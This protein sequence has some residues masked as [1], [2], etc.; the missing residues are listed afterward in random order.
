MA[1]IRKP[2]RYFIN[3]AKRF[4]AE[5]ANS[6][7][8][9]NEKLSRFKW[10]KFQYNFS[11]IENCINT[12]KKFNV[13]AGSSVTQ[14]MHIG[15]V[16]RFLVLR[17]FE[18]LGAESFFAVTDFT[19]K[20]SNPETTTRFIKDIMALGINPNFIV[21]SWGNYQRNNLLMQIANFV[22]DEDLNKTYGDLK[23]DFRGKINTLNALTTMWLPTFISTNPTVVS[24]GIDDYSFLARFKGIMRRVCT[25]NKQITPF[26]IAYS[27]I[28][29]GIDNLKMAKT[30]GENAI[31]LNDDENAIKQKIRKCQ[32]EI[33]PLY[34]YKPFIYMDSMEPKNKEISEF[35]VA[36]EK[37]EYETCGN[38]SSYVISRWIKEYQTER[39]RIEK[40][41]IKQKTGYLGLELNV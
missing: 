11:T 35:T 41:K 6:Q 27:R 25:K 38:I 30:S 24:T 8:F 36:F 33:R 16:A 34:E 12:H 39:K 9:E 3:K 21:D 13:I 40:R 23:I 26:S 17:D 10:I 15:L 1:A 29:P 37:K 20:T 4:G 19:N 2:V 32:M 5:E 28:I 22:S 14:N 31:Y 7:V 18:K